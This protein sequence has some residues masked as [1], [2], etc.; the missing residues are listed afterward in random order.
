MRIVFVNR[1]WMDFESVVGVSSARATTTLDD[2]SCGTHMYIE[3]IVTG[4]VG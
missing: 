2:L 1:R 3:A 4:T